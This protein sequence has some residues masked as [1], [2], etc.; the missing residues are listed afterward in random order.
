MHG[1]PLWRPAMEIRYGDVETRYGDSLWRPDIETHYGDPIWR[2]GDPIWR[3]AMETRYGDPIWR[4]DM[5]MWRRE[6]GRESAN[7]LIKRDSKRSPSTNT[8]LVKRS[9]TSCVIGGFA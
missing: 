3:L 7:T 1:D 9:L 5:E 2:R 4:P 8:D 6:G